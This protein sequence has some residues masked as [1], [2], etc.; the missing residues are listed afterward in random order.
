MDLVEPLI[1]V[2]R[3]NLNSTVLWKNV[4]LLFWCNSPILAE[5]CSFHSFG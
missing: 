2:L 4:F 3:G 1:Y 5:K